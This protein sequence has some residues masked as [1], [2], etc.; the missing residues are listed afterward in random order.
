MRTPFS[1][2]TNTAV[3]FLIL[4]SEVLNELSLSPAVPVTALTA[5]TAMSAI[6][7]SDAVPVVLS[8]KAVTD[9][10]QTLV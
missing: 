9:A 6:A 3:A 7:F 4:P 2:E 1:V 8:V 10:P 5:G